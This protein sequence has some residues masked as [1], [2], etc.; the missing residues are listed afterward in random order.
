MIVT[1]NG[2]QLVQRDKGGAMGG[3]GHIFGRACEQNGVEDRLTSPIIRGP[4]AR[5]NGRCAHQGGHR[6]ILPLRVQQ[7]TAP[8]CPRLASRL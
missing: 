8:S 6:H 7:R 5:P 3:I 1:D 4:T 2:V